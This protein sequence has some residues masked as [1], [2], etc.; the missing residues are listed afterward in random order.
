[1]KK[2]VAAVAFLT[3]LISCS[4]VPLVQR[5][6]KEKRVSFLDSASA[7]YA[8]Y[9]GLDKVDS[10]GFTIVDNCSKFSYRQTPHCASIRDNRKVDSTYFVEYGFFR[11]DTSAWVPQPDNFFTIEAINLRQFQEQDDQ[12]KYTKGSVATLVFGRIIQAAGYGEIEKRNET[13]VDGLS[14]TYTAAAAAGSRV[15]EKGVLTV[16]EG[17][18][19]CYILHYKSTVL[20]F[21]EN[22]PDYVLFEKNFKILE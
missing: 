14:V 16:L 19:F 20:S 1:M 3:L 2:P 9:S 8:C 18:R 11:A 4:T 22:L 5:E 17:G 7:C 12:K 13:T 21:E 6:K 15:R 10:A